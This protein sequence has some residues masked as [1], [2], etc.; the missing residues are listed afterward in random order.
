MIVL[1]NDKAQLDV[2]K[3]DGTFVRTWPVARGAK[4]LLD[5]D[6]NDAVYITAN[7]V[8]ELDIATGRDRVVAT[9]TQMI[10]AQIEP[11]WLAF[12]VPGRVTV[13]RR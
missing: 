5:L 11:R 2:R 13:L 6:G 12:A 9:G 8:H 7:A 1:R 4:P 10:D 3:L